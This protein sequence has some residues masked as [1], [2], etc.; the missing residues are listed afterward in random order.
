MDGIIL[1][2]TA[3]ADGVTPHEA[4]SYNFLIGRDGTI[5]PGSMHPKRRSRRLGREPMP[6]IP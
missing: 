5:T 1:H 6:P 4:D 3:G 2:W